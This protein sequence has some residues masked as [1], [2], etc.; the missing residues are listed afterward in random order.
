MK[1]VALWISN[2]FIPL[3]KS[4]ILM[5]D[6]SYRLLDFRYL[7]IM[8][9]SYFYLITLMLLVSCNSK[10]QKIKPSVEAISE[11]IYA[12]GIVKSKNQYQ[13]FATVNGIIDSIYVSEGDSVKKGTTILQISNETQLL[14]KENAEL[15]AAYADIN[16]NQGQ[17]NEAKLGIDVSL[18]KMR[19]DSLMFVR[20]KSLWSQ[21]IGTKVEV[22]QKELNY[23]N[24]KAAYYSAI[25]RYNDLKR[26]LNLNSAQSKKNLLISKNLTND[27]ILR[28]EIDG[29]VYSLNKTKGEIVG[30]QTPLAVI[31][32][33]KKFTLEMNVD[34]YD[35]MKIRRDL[36]VEVTLDSYKGQVFEAKVTKINPIMDERS[37]TFLVEAE[38]VQTP[39][40]LYPNISFEANI[41]IGTKEKAI[42]IPRNFILND[43]IV[44]KSNGE[45]VVVKV[46]LKDYQKAEILSGITESDELI[47]PKN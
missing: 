34:E 46:G 24:S 26:Q 30:T 42:L 47:E 10:V 35:I 33:A 27:F 1:K 21:K 43:S 25:V 6:V 37:K 8:H 16:A 4:A 19:N 12:S 41:V 29:I 9:K 22:E 36:P 7:S 20:Q 38:F 13:A 2:E 45:K 3:T 23:E 28:S 44:V 5:I 40:L 18:N 32:D 17:L 31:G 14:N 15:L 39:E 11:S